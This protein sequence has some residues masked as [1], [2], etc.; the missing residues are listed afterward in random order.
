MKLCTFD[1]QDRREAG[2][3]LAENVLPV[4][5]VNARAGTKLPADLLALIQA[6]AVGE[7]KEVS[8]GLTADLPLSETRLTLPYP[9]PPKT[10]CIGLNYKSHAE[11]LDE[12]QP[13]EP[14]SFMK[15]SSS[16][17]EPGGAIELPPEDVPSLQKQIIRACREAG[18]PVVVATQMLES[19]ISAPSPTRAE[20]SDVATAVYDGAD[21]VMLS[22]ETAAGA[23]PLEAV[24]IMNRIIE[25]VERD[26]GYRAI[27][28]A[29]HPNPEETAPDA[30]TAAAAQVAST[31]KAAA[32]VTYTTS[33]STSLRASR[34]RPT[35][36]VL[37]LTESVETARRL[38]VAWGIH[39][40][41]TEDVKNF[42]DMVDKACDV[43]LIE[44]FAASGQRV[45]VT[46][47]VPFGTPGATNVL[48]IALVE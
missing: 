38:A 37:C 10:W 28:D 25:R 9:R 42:G 16:I 15:P 33:G 29:V 2:I 19:M 41:I 5:E 23:Y 17:F 6:E 27:M 36:P 30:I 24:A 34:E 1:Y 35:A 48:R 14:G 32:I 40:V 43:A 45:V 4:S 47:G 7:L 21:A 22:A 3:V 18:K 12:V 44:E 20:A 11:D 31:I 39:C 8:S 46:A 13:E 26:T